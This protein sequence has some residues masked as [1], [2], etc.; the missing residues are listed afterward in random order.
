MKT[1]V[2]AYISEKNYE[3]IRKRILDERRRSDSEMIDI[4]VSEIRELEEKKGSRK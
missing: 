4:I 3:Y 2:Q 1:K